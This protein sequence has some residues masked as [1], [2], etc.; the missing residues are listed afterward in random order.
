MATQFDIVFEGGG[1]KGIDFAGALKAL[2][3]KKYG[4]RRLVGTS[5]GAISATLCAVDYSSKEL[6]EVITERTTDGR[7]VFSTF[8]DKP[9]AS[10]FSEDIISNSFTMKALKDIDLPLIPDSFEGKIDDFIIKNLL[11]SHFYARQFSFIECGGFYS[12]STFHDWM[13]ARLKQKGYAPDITL[14]DLFSKTNRDL[15]LV[16]TNVT[17]QLLLILNHR[18]TPNLPVARAVRMSM[19]IPIVWQEVTWNSVWGKY[20]PSEKVEIELTDS[21]IVDGGVLSN[22]PMNLIAEFSSSEKATMGKELNAEFVNKAENLG[23]LIDESLPVPDQPES[24]SSKKL[25]DDL[26]TIGRVH[27]IAE[28][29]MKARDNSIIDKYKAEI[30]RLPANG[31]GTLEFD[32]QGDRLEALIKAGY[33]AT[34]AHL[35]SRG[36]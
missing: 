20:K 7:P 34:V 19:S 2:E 21:K 22:F 32:I 1:A 6:L 3:E 16:A 25:I 11:K 5:A 24:K 15:S 18:T 36:M 29:M 23:L 10:D 14:A 17:Q 35:A 13:R 31:Y 9:K 27:K 8:M 33:D 28:T 30:C 12:G 26:P 4:Y